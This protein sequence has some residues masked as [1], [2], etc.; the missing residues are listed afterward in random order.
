MPPVCWFIPGPFAPTRNTLPANTAANPNR[1][2][3]NFSVLGSTGCFQ[4][5]PEMPLRPANAGSGRK[6]RVVKLLYFDQWTGFDAEAVEIEHRPQPER[7]GWQQGQR[8][9]GL[10]AQLGIGGLGFA[11]RHR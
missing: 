3:C 7:T 1:S 5:F 10:P 4:T 8:N 11:D 6:F 2:I 9:P